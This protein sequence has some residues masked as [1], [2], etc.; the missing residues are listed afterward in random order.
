MKRKPSEQQKPP[1]RAASKATWSDHVIVGNTSARCKHCKATG[2]LDGPYDPRVLDK[3]DEE[4]AKA[5]SKSR[6]AYVDQ[7]WEFLR[8]HKQCLPVEEPKQ[9]KRSARSVGQKGLFA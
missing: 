7:V 5:Q 2:K 3:D 9:K 6:K 4:A 8:A 1:D